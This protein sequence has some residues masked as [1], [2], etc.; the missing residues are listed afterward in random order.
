MYGLQGMHGRDL[1]HADIICENELLA[2]VPTKLT[3]HDGSG[4]KPSTVGV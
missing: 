3:G 2:E 4:N 1:I